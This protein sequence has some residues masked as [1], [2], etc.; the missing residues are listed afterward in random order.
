MTHT[1]SMRH[2]LR[3]EVAGTIG[4]LADEQ[5]FTAMRRYRTFTFDDHTTYLRQVEGLLKTLA[6]DGGHTAVALFD[7][8]EYE[9]FCTE[10]GLDPDAPTSRT[11]FTAELAA[12]GPSIPYEGQP[13]A[14]LVPELVEE[15]VRQAT[16]EYASA[17]LARIGPCVICGQDIGRIA[18]ARAAY[19][20]ARVIDTIDEGLHHWVCSVPTDRESLLA[21]L[22]V[23]T[24][25]PDTVRLEETSAME[26]TTVLALAVA[27]RTPCALV[28]RTTGGGRQQ[29]YGWRLK[30]EELKPLTASQVFDAYCTDP[31]S[32]DLKS[33][34]PGV[35]YC[36]APE[37]DDTDI[38][39]RHRH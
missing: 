17:V 39:G 20:V 10:T 11:R 2:V 31:H 6:A 29:V 9:E 27:T 18:F 37:V 19:L 35:D 13:L 14:E 32:G 16:W 26:L 1:T 34:E 8:V 23:D 30:E 28:L 12:T 15:A 7:P 33:P 3:R 24:T 21:V 25:E 4:L 22:H 38:E 36:T 5:D